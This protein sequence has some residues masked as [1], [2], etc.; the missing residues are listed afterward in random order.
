MTASERPTF[1]RPVAARLSSSPK[2]VVLASVA[3]RRRYARTVPQRRRAVPLLATGLVLIALGVC[4]LALIPTTV[5]GWFAY[6]PVSEA[7]F[8]RGTFLQP[9][10]LAG[11]A[12][13]VPGLIGAS[14]AAGF[15]AGTRVKPQT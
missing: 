12:L 1:D 15:L 6:A 8:S 11:A 5:V 3:G 2:H 7:T 10:H 4:V 14:W 9:S 13:L